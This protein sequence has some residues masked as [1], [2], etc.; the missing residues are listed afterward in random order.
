MTRDELFTR[1]REEFGTEPDY[2]WND[3]NAVFRHRSTKK[4]FAVLIQVER[5]R[6]GLEGTG[7]VDLVNVKCDPALV[8]FLRGR[9][10]YLPAYHMNKELWISMRLD[11]A[12]EAGEIMERIAESR[13]LTGPKGLI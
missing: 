7:T 9:E 2:P 11:G 1:I 5:F 4:W 8:G 6:V 3:E 10:G 13:R 12:L